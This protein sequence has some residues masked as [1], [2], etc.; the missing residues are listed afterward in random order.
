[1]T[2]NLVRDRDRIAGVLGGRKEEKMAVD[3]NTIRLR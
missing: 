3:E 2:W 1:M